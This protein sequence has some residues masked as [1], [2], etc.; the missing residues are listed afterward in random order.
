MMKYHM[1]ISAIIL[2]LI[3]YVN[4]S[5]AQDR[6][7]PS[8]TPKLV[9]GIQVSG[10]RYD[11]LARYWDKLGD[12]GFRRLIAKGTVC[13]NAHHDYLVPESGSGYASI[14][15]GTYPDV[16]GVVSN[17]WY[18]RLREKVT[19]CI[20][21]EKAQTVGG[22]YEQGKYSPKNIMVSTISDELKLS[23]QFRS[24]VISISMDPMGAVISGGH[25]ANGCYW[26]DNTN[27]QWIT[28]DYYT[29][30][31]PKWVSDFND[32]KFADLYL[33]RT[34]ETMLPPDEYTASLPDTSY[35]ETGFDGQHSF[36]YNLEKLSH[37]KR[38][39]VNYALLKATPFGNTYTSDFAASAVVNEKLGKD[40]YTDWL[41]VIYTANAYA[42]DY[43]SSRSVE[44][45]DL[46]LRLDK[47]IEHFL[48]FLDK[49]VGLKN[50]LIYLTADNASANEPGYLNGNR[51]PSGY[52]NYNAALSLLKTYLNV[53][54]G[55]GDWVKFYYGQ[56][57]YL[58]RVLIE[59]SRLSI[60][61]FQDRVARFMV[62]F[63]G[64]SN[65]L[66]ASDL[67]KNN[68]TGGTFGSIQKSYNQKRSGDVLLYLTPGWI[69][70]GVDR[71]Y[72][73][74]VH[75]D[76]HVPLIW[77]GWKIGRKSIS[78][79]VSVTDIMPTIA[80]FLNISTPPGMEGSIIGEIDE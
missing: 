13:R 3:F 80:N 16:H 64:V 17:Y 15:T 51:M 39:Q 63:E 65:A 19:Y 35:L 1:R 24:K 54:Y 12:G 14:A 4:G 38:N 70:K 52:F 50:V 49:E 28:S 41:N 48:D 69:E 21:D 31:L 71:Q 59:D 23:D 8:E 22:N 27:G 10:M 43:F 9:V 34:W 25:T 73:S 32:K 68:Y 2:S 72:A 47:D 37:A 42:G 20:G 58:N 60:P 62:Q 53:I 30:S 29:D 77:Y 26:Y 79:R 45:E 74:S 61:E 46:Y 44:M 36:P 78:R 75:Y 5:Y 11:Y 76:T 7:I 40:G 55:N 6:A 33:S 67:V 56:Q 66:T 57:I 18:D